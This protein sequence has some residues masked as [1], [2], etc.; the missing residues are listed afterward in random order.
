M[1]PK[2]Y[3]EQ[4]TLSRLAADNPSIKDVAE[5]VK[6]IYSRLWSKD[7]ITALI[8]QTHTALCVECP[9]VKKQGIKDFQYTD[10]K[11][12]KKWYQKVIWLLLTTAG[13]VVGYFIKNHE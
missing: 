9:H 1:E 7:E 4:Q 3:L 6:M 11:E 2:E 13:A 12:D 10:A 8:V 5:G